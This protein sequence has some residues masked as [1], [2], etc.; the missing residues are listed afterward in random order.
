MLKDL[1]R[2]RLLAAADEIFGM[3]ETAI[4]SYEEQLCRARAETERQRVEAVCKTQ[5]VTR[6][7][8]VQRL[9]AHQ[10][11]QPQLH[12]HPQRPLKEEEEASA[13]MLP[14]AGESA[15]QECKEEPS[16][17]QRGEPVPEDLQA[18]PA[19]SDDKEEIELLRSNEDREGDGRPSKC[20]KKKTSQKGIHPLVGRQE[21][22]AEPQG[23]SPIL[24]QK[25]PQP[26]HV[27]EDAAAP[28]FRHVEEEDAQVDTFPLTGVSV[29]SEDYQDKPLEWSQLHRDSPSGDHCGG[30]PP[31]GLLAPLSDSDG[32]EVHLR[33]D[34]DCE[35]D[36]EQLKC[37]E[38]VKIGNKKMT[39]M[40]K[41]GFPCSV[42][43][44]SLANKSVLH[45]HMRTHTGEK[46][47]SCSVCGQKFSEKQVMVKH[48]RTHTG[49]KP[50]S[51]LVC[52]RKFSQKQNMVIHMGTHTKEKRFICSVCGKKFSQKQYMIRHMRTHTRETL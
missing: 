8:D 35:G 42:C 28:Q 19:Q 43:G 13:I 7:Q 9:I 52:G 47:F 39:Q 27:K 40:R 29:E 30:P 18:P 21:L 26:F 2:E 34:T 32:M 6:I 46:P 11:H 25:D 51:C 12:E 23:K 17:D 4:A 50:F 3:F 1:V 44:K 38:K 22:P 33:S 37:S 48:I 10:A 20:S 49:E 14:L 31:V 36:N 16:G 5:V 24:G 15:V 41:K 45:R